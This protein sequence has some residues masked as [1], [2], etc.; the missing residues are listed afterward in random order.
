[1]AESGFYCSGK[2]KPVAEQGEEEEQKGAT[3]VLL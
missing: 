1:M 3:S 2:A